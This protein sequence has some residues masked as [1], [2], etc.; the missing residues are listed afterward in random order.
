MRSRI[1][2]LSFCLIGSLAAPVSASDV[3]DL[4]TVEHATAL[5]PEIPTYVTKLEAILQQH[6]Q[7]CSAIDHINAFSTGSGLRTAVACNGGTKRYEIVFE[8]ES[9]TVT[10]AN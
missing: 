1:G 7:S 5:N 4:M 8:G 10:S 6:G 2:L 3:S 9:V